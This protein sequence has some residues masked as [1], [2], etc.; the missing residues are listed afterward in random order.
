M[1]GGRRGAKG[2][3][4]SLFPMSH[5]HIILFSFLHKGLGV[6]GLF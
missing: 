1:N 3:L 6:T 4:N 2:D 5:F